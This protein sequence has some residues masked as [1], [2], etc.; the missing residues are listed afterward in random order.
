M[1][2]LQRLL[3][4]PTHV[5]GDKLMAANKEVCRARPRAL[6]CAKSVVLN[7]QLHQEHSA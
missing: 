6:L 7:E 3:Q 4:I 5:D 2:T 1:N